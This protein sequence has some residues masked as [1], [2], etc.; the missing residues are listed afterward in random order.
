MPMMTSGAI[1]GG[2]GGPASARNTGRPYLGIRGAWGVEPAMSEAMA[3]AAAGSLNWVYGI[4]THPELSE[5][6]SYQYTEKTPISWPLGVTSCDQAMSVTVGS[7]RVASI[8][9]E[10]PFAIACA[11]ARVVVVRARN[12]K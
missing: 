12:S 6:S 3:S 8:S 11:C 10:T 4:S 9:A 7:W 2:I 1:A 5:A